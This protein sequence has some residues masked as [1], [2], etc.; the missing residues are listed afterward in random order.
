MKTELVTSLKR[1]ATEIIADL[2]ESRDP[3]LITQHGKPAAYL[4]VI[5]TFEGL[6]RKL[7]ILEGSAEAKAM[8]RRGGP[9]L[10]RRPANAWRNGSNKLDRICLGRFERNCGIHCFG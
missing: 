3:V 4:I 6:T 5:E 1:K 9:S 8:L 7:N 2:A 10:M